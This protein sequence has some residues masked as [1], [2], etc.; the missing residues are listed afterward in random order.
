MQG[1]TVVLTGATAG[2]GLAAAR[3]LAQLGARLVLIGRDR[4]RGEQARAALR[5]AA[6]AA[7][8]ADLHL[9]D[10]A[11]LADVHRL[12]AELGQH[13]PRVDVLINNAGVLP[14]RLTTTPEGHE[15]CWA[16]NHLA[17]FILTNHLLPQLEAAGPGARV[18]TVASDAHW[19]GEIESTAAARIDSNRSSAL[20][21]Y[22]D[23]K[24][25]NILFTKALSE[26]L[27]LTGITAHCLHPGVVSSNLWSHS[28]LLVR[29]LMRLAAPFA[30]LP[31][32]A[33]AT[34]VHLATTTDAAA[35]DGH[36]FKNCRRARTSGRADNRAEMHR[37]W[38][39]SAEE[40]GIGQ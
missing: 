28:P 14:N 12:G 11:N 8:E 37:L 23:S 38:R 5:L 34:I 21:A 10:L 40:T 36:Y 32:Q 17:P 16:T 29:A 3:Q 2:I 24:L 25:A 15:L 20:T 13:Y 33:A 1:R 18:I 22:C 39:I 6:P 30:K 26:R 4:M 35:A 7:P 31:E 27:E 9:C 19:L